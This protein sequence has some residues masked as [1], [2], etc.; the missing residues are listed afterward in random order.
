MSNVHVFTVG[1]DESKMTNFRLTANKFN[2][3]YTNLGRG[4]IWEGGNTNGPGCGQ[5][6][7]CHWQRWSVLGRRKSH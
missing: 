7:E 2:I 3:N 6:L 1:T 4:V 5:N